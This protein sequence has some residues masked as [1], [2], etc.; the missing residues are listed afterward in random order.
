MQK[1]KVDCVISKHLKNMLRI[2]SNA[3]ILLRRSMR[4]MCNLQIAIAFS[5]IVANIFIRETILINRFIEI[6]FRPFIQVTPEEIEAQALR[7]RQGRSIMDSALA[8]ARALRASL[9]APDKQKL[10]EY[11]STNLEHL[12]KIFR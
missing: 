6:K 1:S 9:N 12:E 7:L 8:Q 4:K 11:L 2:L 10:D 5:N 3:A